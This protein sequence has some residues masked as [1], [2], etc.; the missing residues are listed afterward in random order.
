LVLFVLR[1]DLI[2]STA[3]M[4]SWLNFNLFRPKLSPN[5]IKNGHF[6]NLKF[7]QE[8]ILNQIVS[9]V[10]SEFNEYLIVVFVNSNFSEF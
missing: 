1:L 10:N 7:N 8:A 3:K 4:A 2:E 9:F 6:E 5:W